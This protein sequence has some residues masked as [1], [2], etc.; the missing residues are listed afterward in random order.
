MFDKRNHTS[1]ASDHV[2]TKNKCLQI[3]LI[4][5]INYKFF[6]LKGTPQWI[7]FAFEEPQ[8]IAK[9]NI[10]FQGGFAGKDSQVFFYDSSLELINTENIYPEDVNAQQTFEFKSPVANVKKMKIIFSTSTD[11][12]GRIIVYNIE[13]F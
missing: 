3:I 13:I 7:A 1:W 11:F 12:F 8:T 5:F 10:Q 9:L 6:I 4:L 2:S